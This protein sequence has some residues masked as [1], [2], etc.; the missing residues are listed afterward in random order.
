MTFDDITVMMQK[1]VA[2]RLTAAPS[3]KD[4]GSLT[5]GVQQ[6]MN[7]EVAFTVSRTAFVPAPNVDSA[8]V[9]LTK[10]TT[11]LVEISDQ[12][13]FDRLVKGS[14]AARR[15]T[16]WNNLTNLF[17]K[18]DATKAKLTSALDAVQVTPSARAETLS[19]P[20]FAALAEALK[21]NGL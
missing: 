6:R 11:P 3:S 9:N 10:R 13:A 5:I 8:I 20:Q 21:A 12:A 17:G 1:E 2:D 4:Y 7:V 16:L 19:I 14:F 18:D 15:K